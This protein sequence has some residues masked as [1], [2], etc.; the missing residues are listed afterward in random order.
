MCV[1]RR[2]WRRVA[3]INNKP[4]LLKERERERERKGAMRR[5]IYWT[6]KVRMLCDVEL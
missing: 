5:K 6:A 1:G 3:F 2:N 4:M